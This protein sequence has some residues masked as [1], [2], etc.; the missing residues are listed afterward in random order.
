MHVA[1]PD[2]REHFRWNLGY[3]T[4]S[5]RMMFSG[6]LGSSLGESFWCLESLFWRVFDQIGSEHWKIRH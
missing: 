6:C 2:H 1:I 3:F 5:S 4:D